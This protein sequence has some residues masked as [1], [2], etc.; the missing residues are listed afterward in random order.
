MADTKWLLLR[1][2]AWSC[3]KEVPRPLQAAMGCRR[4]VVSLRTRDLAKAQARRWEALAAFARQFAEAKRESGPS[5]PVEIGLA[6]KDTLARLRANDPATVRVFG[7]ENYNWYHDDSEDPSVPVQQRALANAEQELSDLAGHLRDAKGPEQASLMVD[8]ARGRA[9]PLL[10]HV[11]MWLAEGGD[12][13]PYNERTKGQH[14]ADMTALGAWLRTAGVPETVEA[15]TRQVAGRHVNARMSAPGVSRA[16]VNRKVSAASGYWRWLIKRGHASDNP[17]SGQSLAKAR[18]SDPQGPTKKRPFTDAEMVR[19]LAG[20]ADAELADAMRMAALTGARIE[21]L[22]RIRV[23]D[24]RDDSVI[25]VPPQKKEPHARP[26]P[27]HPDLRGIVARRCEGKA[28]DAYLFHEA[29]PLRPGRERSMAVSKRFG[30]YRKRMGVHEQSEG[31][32]QSAVDFHSFRR[33]FATEAE[34]AGVPRE[35]VA[36]VIGHAGGSGASDV[37]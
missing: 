20:D 26:V 18:A 12:A 5:D 9:T 35:T 24:V 8:V 6:W 37:R 25:M 1:H 34:R 7:A 14:R 36:A 28:A 13:G 19:L 10:L 23:R 17:W 11:D 31:A 22:F 2:Q 27:I 21:A 33:W 30:H 16:T 15:V 4:L 32:R 29:G 3:V